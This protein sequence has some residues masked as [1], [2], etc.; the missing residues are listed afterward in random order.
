MKATINKEQRKKER[1]QIKESNKVFER[2]Y[3]LQFNKENKEKERKNIN[4]INFENIL[5]VILENKNN[6][7][8]NKSNK[9]FIENIK[10]NSNKFYCLKLN[11]ESLDLLNLNYVFFESHYKFI[12]NGTNKILLSIK[13]IPLNQYSNESYKVLI[14][15]IMLNDSF[16][17]FIIFNKKYDYKFK[18]KIFDLL[19]LDYLQILKRKN[20]NITNKERELLKSIENSKY[21]YIDNNERLENFERQIKENNKKI[22][23]LKRKINNNKKHNEYLKKINKNKELNESL[24]RLDKYL[25]IYYYL[26]NNNNYLFNQIDKIL[27]NIELFESNNI[28]KYKTYF[29]D[30][31]NFYYT[32]KERKILNL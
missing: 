10:E 24:E 30:Y 8:T 12:Y 26:S 25:N 4:I 14:L 28:N 23:S 11:K 7:F 1:E 29:I 6:V 31:E 15:S 3:Y 19:S 9:K 27:N 18:L 16:N 13:N 22:E 20:T 21:Y 2:L 5:R 17:T 32:F